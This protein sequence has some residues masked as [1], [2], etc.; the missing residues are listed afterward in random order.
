[1]LKCFLPLTAILLI[2]MSRP[3]NCQVSVAPSSLYIHSDSDV[4]SLYVSNGYEEAREIST[5]FEFGYLSSDTAGNQMMVYDDTVASSRYGL[6]NHLKAF[7]RKFVLAP[8]SSQTIRVQVR[9]MHDKPDGVYWNRIIISS[10]E[11][12]IYKAGS[13]VA[14]GIGA[15]INYVVKHNLAVFY[16]KGKTDTG[17]APGDVTTTLDE[18]KL[19]V[20]VSLAREGNSPFNGS[21]YARLSD[22]KQRELAFVRQTLVVYFDILQKIEFDLP[23]Q[24]LPP[25]DYI[26]EL[27]YQTRRSDISSAD[28]IQADPLHQKINLVI[29]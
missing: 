10:N 28:L 21:V 17:L 26:L 11:A 1:V 23:R 2:T 22:S 3:A 18:G 19:K 7:P 13:D 15:T 29:E 12:M 24:G 5:D 25:G 8:G 4:A 27:S 20:L 14:E 9:N 16:R 6:E